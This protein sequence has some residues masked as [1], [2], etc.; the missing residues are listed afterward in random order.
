MTVRELIEEL[1]Q[2]AKEYGDEVE[3]AVLHK[4]N[5]NGGTYTVYE[6]PDP[7]YVWREIIL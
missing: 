2:Y 4:K 6:E 5:M 7:C 3:V 1:E